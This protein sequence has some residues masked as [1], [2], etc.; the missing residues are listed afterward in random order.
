[1]KTKNYK[2][3]SRYFFSYEFLLDIYKCIR[4]L[5]LTEYPENLLVE[6]L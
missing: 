2:L 6:S 5:I 3:G 4:L 1:M